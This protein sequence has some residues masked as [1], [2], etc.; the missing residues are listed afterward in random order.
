M[1]LVPSVTVI[2]VQNPPADASSGKP[3]AGSS[4]FVLDLSPSDA[5]N[6]VF[7]VDHSTLYMGLLPS[8]NKSGY[9]QPGV[10]GPP[11]ARVVGVNKG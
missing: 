7:A 3:T 10:I 2:A 4:T 5:A 11:L 1:Q 6:V 8:Q 9:S